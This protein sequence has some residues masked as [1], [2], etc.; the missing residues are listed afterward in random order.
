MKQV[1][2]KFTL[3]F[4]ERER[5]MYDLSYLILSNSD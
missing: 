2:K 1:F 4:K 5:F 3:K